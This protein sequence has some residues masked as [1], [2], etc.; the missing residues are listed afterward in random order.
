MEQGDPVKFL[1]PTEP[2]DAHAIL[3]KLALETMEH[4]VT[5]MFTADQPTSLKNSIYVDADRYRWRS[6]DQYHAIVENDYDVVWWRRAR[7]P[8]IP[9][10]YVHPDDYRFVTRENVL[11]YESFTHTFAS[12]AWWVNSKEAANRANFKLL[13]LKIAQECGMKVP[14][15]LCSNDPKEIRYFLLNYEHEG[16]I[17]KPLCSNFWFE[18]DCVKIAYTA[19]LGFVDLPTNQSLQRTPGIF[20]KEVKKKYELRITCFGRHIVA[21]KLDSQVHADGQVDWRAIREGTLAIEP[22]ELP[23]VLQEQIRAFMYRVGIVFGTFDFIVTPDDEY[24]FLEVNEQGQFLWIEEYNPVFPM[25]DLFVQFLTNQG[26]DSS[27]EGKQREHR[28]TQY[29][30]QVEPIFT[31]NRQRHV[32]LNRAPSHLN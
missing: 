5:L 27:L 7:K 13:Q 22:Y 10:E 2:D 32:D 28:I 18:K 6:E 24:I 11:F 26:V 31:A 21:A 19:R 17:Y 23:Q 29:W 16:V 25:L 1:I 9:E 8:Y 30:N 4:D 20:Q 3:V 14:M 12:H 15:T